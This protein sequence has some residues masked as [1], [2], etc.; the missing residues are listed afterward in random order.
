[1][2]G[3]SAVKEIMSFVNEFG[4][5]P[6]MLVICI[7][8]YF[9]NK[10]N[11]KSFEKI[12]QSISSLKESIENVKNKSDDAD[13]HIRVAFEKQ[14][15]KI[16][17]QLTLLGR[18]IDYIGSAYIPKEQH[19]KDIEGWKAEINYLRKETSRMPY[20]LMRLLMQQRGGKNETESSAG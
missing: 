7:I 10:D 9:L 4:F 19:Y 14:F 3:L 11:K 12:N 13:K 1:M 20:E 18:E 5:I 15:D 2:E 16:T 17:E 8:F 6:V